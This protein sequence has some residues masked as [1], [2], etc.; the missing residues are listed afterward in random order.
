[1]TNKR[2]AKEGVFHDLKEGDTLTFI[3]NKLPKYYL[4]GNKVNIINNDDGSININQKWDRVK[5]KEKPSIIKIKTNYD[6]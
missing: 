1:M 2:T 3:T 4:K 5:L 6:K